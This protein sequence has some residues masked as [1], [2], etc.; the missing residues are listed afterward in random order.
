MH[1]LLVQVEVQIN[2]AQL[3]RSVVRVVHTV[4]SE[5]ERVP[6]HSTPVEVEGQ[7]VVEMDAMELEQV[8]CLWEQLVTLEAQA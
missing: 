2:L 4:L 1:C 8:G 5:A 6:K 7:V 3:P